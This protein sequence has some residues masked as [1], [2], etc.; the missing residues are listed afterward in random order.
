MAMTT[1][2][3]PRSLTAH[4]KMHNISKP[5]NAWEITLMGDTH[6]QCEL[7]TEEYSQE[8]IWLWVLNQSTFMWWCSD[9]HVQCRV[10]VYTK[11]FVTYKMATNDVTEWLTKLA[12]LN[13]K[14]LPSRWA[15]VYNLA[16]LCSR[17]FCIYDDWSFCYIF[18][19]KAFFHVHL[20]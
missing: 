4:H 17:R 9:M 16:S 8:D 7:S 19:R 11:L 10:A 20:Y 5:C 18:Q 1:K 6:S 14:L 2:C 13:T 3:H 15:Y 12:K